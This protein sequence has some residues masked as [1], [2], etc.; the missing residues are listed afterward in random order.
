MGRF[1]RLALRS[2]FALALLSAAAP[3]RVARAAPKAGAETPAMAEARR[4]FEVGLAMLK[5][6]NFSAALTEFRESYALGHRPSALRNIAQCQRE[7]HEYASA[8]GT[9]ETL[10]SAHGGELKPADR[11]A[12]QRAL[13]ELRQLTA[14]V[15][16]RVSPAGA[17]VA[18]DGSKRGVTPLERLRV[19]AGTRK[20]RITKPGFEPL[21]KTLEI[22]SMKDTAIGGELVAEVSTGRVVVRELSGIPVTVFI[23]GKSVGMAPY[24]AE[25]PPGAHVV[26]GR[27]DRVVAKP[28]TVEV[29][30]KG[31]F[32]VVLETAPITGKLRIRAT[33]PSATVS[34]DGAAPRLGGF[35]GDLALGR[36]ALV[37]EAPGYARVERLVDVV[38]GESVVQDVIL[39][40]IPVAAPD[41]GPPVPPPHVDPEPDYQGFY[42][43][44]ALHYVQG[45]TA[46]PGAPCPKD[47]N[48]YQCASGDPMGGASKLRL[49]YSFGVIGLEGVAGAEVDVRSDERKTLAIVSP[50]DAQPNVSRT[51]LTMRG[52]F[53]GGLRILTPG[54]VRFTIGATPGYAIQSYSVRNTYAT[55]S[56]YNASASGGN[57]AMLLDAGFL[58]GPSPG[59]KVLLGVQAFADF[60][61]A[62]TF[63]APGSYVDTT[64]VTRSEP[65]YQVAPSMNWF[66]LPTFGFQFGH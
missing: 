26:E 40:A 32:E 8:F 57:F 14:L 24:E 64:R 27:S 38:A 16:V 23:D 15:D 55:G 1:A 5:E 59:T 56:S 12:I 62:D 6:R 63:T 4:H 30:K 47:A 36:H 3:V 33:P 49:G 28:R 17:E 34:I 35:E 13:E 54:H 51:F 60:V 45:L 11:T 7:M 37:V 21:E 66:I 58:F 39:A 18:V 19:D 9:L 31:R 20:L 61:G 48:T 50:A 42:T 10:L 53:G 29:V 25:L 2:S 44:L 65:A 43:Q 22:V 41:P 52:F 46:F